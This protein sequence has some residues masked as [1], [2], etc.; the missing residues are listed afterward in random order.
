MKKFI[1]A[2]KYAWEHKDTGCLEDMIHELSMNEF[3]KC[4]QL[5][6][7]IYIHATDFATYQ[8]IPVT[9]EQA[10]KI[11]GVLHEKA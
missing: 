3:D 8:I 9:Q 6:E 10:I 2:F 7:V 11:Y 1:R 5:T 4:K